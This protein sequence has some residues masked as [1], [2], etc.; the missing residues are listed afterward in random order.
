M[1]TRRVV[2]DADQKGRM[3]KDA[4]QKGGRWRPEGSMLRRI[5]TRPEKPGRQTV[6]TPEKA[7]IPEKFGT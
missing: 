5:P 2:V 4:D 6:D 7:G 3:G 1:P